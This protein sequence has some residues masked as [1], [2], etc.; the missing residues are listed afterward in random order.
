MLTPSTLLVRGVDPDPVEWVNPGSTVPVLLVCEHA[1]QVVPR[2]LDRLGLPD[3]V[4]GEHIGWDIGAAA[5]THAM[6]ENLG[7]AAILQRYSR[8]VID[9]NRPTDAD[10]LI[11]EMT[12]GQPVPGNREL[13]TADRD[14]RIAEIFAPFDAA[15]TQARSSGTELLL[16]IHSFTPELLSTPGLRPWH[17]GFLCRQDTDTSERLLAKIR[18]LRTDFT[19]ALNEPYQIDSKS[20]WFVPNHGEASG[21]PHSLI[22]IRNDLIRHPD[23]QRELADLLSQAVRSIL[24]APC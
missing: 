9:C 20:D 7:C 18:V 15:V 14:K 22:E 5:V 19:L 13:T 23:G 1:G 4:I 3:D 10:D 21:I 17:I 11:P 24:E 8:I 16:S 2:N 6:A 12:D